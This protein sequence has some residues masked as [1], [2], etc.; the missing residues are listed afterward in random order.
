MD[1]RGHMA[2]PHFLGVVVPTRAGSCLWLLYME[3]VVVAP[4]AHLGP[5]SKRAWRTLSELHVIVLDARR[6]TPSRRPC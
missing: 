4:L 3:P 5:V 6:A 2:D 1:G